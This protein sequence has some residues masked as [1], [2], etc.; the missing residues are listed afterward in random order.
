MN[1]YHVADLFLEIST[2]EFMLLCVSSGSVSGCEE[3]EGA[4]VA[5]SN[6]ANQKLGGG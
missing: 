2:C 4:G 3:E 6:G 1:L 5:D